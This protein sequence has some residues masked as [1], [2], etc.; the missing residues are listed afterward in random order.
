MKYDTKITA[1]DVALTDNNIDTL[2][3][4][5]VMKMRLTLLKYCRVRMMTVV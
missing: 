5:L 1:I 2:K 3:L 4:L